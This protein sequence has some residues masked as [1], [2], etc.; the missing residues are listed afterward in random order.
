MLNFICALSFQL[1][2]HMVESASNFQHS[3]DI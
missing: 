3:I 2:P 1:S